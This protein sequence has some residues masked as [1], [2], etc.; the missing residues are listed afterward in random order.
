MNVLLAR[1]RAELRGFL[2]SLSQTLEEAGVHVSVG[3][4]PTMGALHEGHASLIRRSSKETSI[5][6]VSIFVNPKQFGA[7][8]DLAKYPRTLEADLSVCENA[9]AHI[10]FA[11]SAEEMYPADFT[12]QVSVGGMADVLCGAYRSG[13][14]SGVCTVVLLLL[15]LVRADQAYFGLK[16]FQQFSILSRMVEDLV[17]PTR[18]VGIPT[19]RDRDGV[20]L[21]SRN[22]FLDAQ[23]RRLALKIPAAL[24]TVAQSFL[25]GMSKSSELLSLC[26]SSLKN[27]DGFEVQ[28]CEIRDAKTLGQSSETIETDHVLAVAVFV[29]GADGVKT[30]LIDNILLTHDPENLSALLDFAHESVAL[31]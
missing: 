13:H 21:S 11:P 6:V 19:V 25:Q 24:K 30:R 28:Y 20:A 10:V 22:K 31:S 5:T 12:T 2:S 16:D 1:T 27:E 15:N 9:G 4:V 18:L 8:E 14:F 17:H 7:N 23:A 3:F 26:L 29:T